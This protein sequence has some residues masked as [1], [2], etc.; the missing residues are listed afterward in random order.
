MKRIAIYA[1]A[2]LAAVSS[3]ANDFSGKGG[4]CNAL[5][6]SQRRVADLDTQVGRMNAKHRDNAAVR[7]LSTKL[8]GKNAVTKRSEL[9]KFFAFTD[10]MDSTAMEKQVERRLND[11]QSDKVSN[12]D[13]RKLVGILNGDNE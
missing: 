9:V 8:A 5:L 3:F 12:D 13:V 7:E 10:A 6:C 1:L 2:G 4:A 11:N